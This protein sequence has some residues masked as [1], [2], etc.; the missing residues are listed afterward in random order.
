MSGQGKKGIK[1]AIPTDKYQCIY[2]LSAAD[3]NKT[4]GGWS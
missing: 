2:Y 1:L 3:L 4:N